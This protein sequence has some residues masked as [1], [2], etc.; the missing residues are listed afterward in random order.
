MPEHLLVQGGQVDLLGTDAH[1][2]GESLVALEVEPAAAAAAGES[3]RSDITVIAAGPAVAKIHVTYA[4]DYTC[5]DPQTLSGT[6]DFTIFPSGRIVREDS[7]QP[8]TGT[9]GKTGACGCQQETDPQNFHDLSFSSFWAFAP[10]GA[11][12]V[13]ADGSPV[14]VD[15]FDACTQYATRSVAVSW[16]MQAGTST[17]YHA[18]AAASHILDWTSDATSLAPDLKSI[19]STIQI[20][21]TGASC[22]DVL[23]RTAFAGLSVDD[24][25]LSAPDHDGIYR[26]PMPHKGSF[27]IVPSGKALPPGF[28]MSIDL[29]GAHHALITRTPSIAGPVAVVQPDDGDRYLLF[30]PAGLA[31]GESITIEPQS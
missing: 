13:Q 14:D 1:C 30:F 6:T 27:V 31:L 28:A 29:G 15:V 21:N 12:Q 5:P 17:R 23:A 2:Q 9:L 18:S 4:V 7:G 10:D 16:V 26:D 25:T 24:V 3:G 11:T 19:A 20:D 8:S 22:H